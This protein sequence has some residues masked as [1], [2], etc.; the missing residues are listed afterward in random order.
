MA[1]ALENYVAALAQAKEI[2]A[3]GGAIEIQSGG[4]SHG[5]T[6]ILYRIHATRLKCLIT[7]AKRHEDEFQKAEE[8]A[9]RLTER[10]PF[11]EPESAMPASEEHVRDRIWNVLADIV[12][13]LAQ[14]RVDQPYFHRSVYRHA[15]ALCWAPI[16]YDPLSTEGSH[17]T[18]PATRGFRIRGLNNSTAVSQSAEI[19][20]NSLF[21]KKRSQL[22]AVWVTP[23]SAAS[24]FQALNNSTRKYDSL[25]GKYIS[26]Y[27]ELLRLSQR[28]GKLE[29][30]LKGTY[31]CR[32]DVAC[33]FQ[34]SALV[35][36]GIPPKSHANEPILLIHNNLREHGFL[37]TVKREANSALADILIHEITER[38]T[39]AQSIEEKKKTENF[40]KLA[41]ST[42]LRLNCSREDLDRCRAWKYGAN[43]LREVE[44]VCQAFLA[45]GSDEEV[46]E[47]SGGSAAFGDWSGGGRKAKIFDAAIEKCKKMFPTLTG[48]YFSK[49]AIA[50]V[51]SKKNAG[52]EPQQAGDKRKEPPEEDMVV[53]PYEVAVPSGVSAGDSFLTT[54]R[55]GDFTKKL[56]LTVP[57]TNPTTLRFTVKVPKSSSEQA[58]KK[59]KGDGPTPEE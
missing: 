34:A 27:V 30:F 31:S 26:A 9:L 51:K 47:V 48:S 49:K 5:H 44:A 25:R 14:C 8:E 16:L 3:N 24:P 56:K 11:Q 58:A 12:S 40:L 57:E 37:T 54:V 59:A 7:A 21:D 20:M 17:D 6:E 46:T 15:Q 39:K 10:H 4:S 13:A 29:T 2:E 33:Y 22:C 28:R 50:A 36:G 41:Y 32:R 38:S 42:Y 1:L 53:M 18:V 23:T 35:G 43:T 55:V 52:N 19:V 45:Y